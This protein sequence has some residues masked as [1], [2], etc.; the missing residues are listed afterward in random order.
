VFGYAKTTTAL[1]DRMTHHWHF[2]ET[3]NESH[4]F[5]NSTESARKQ[6]RKREEAK[7][8][9]KSEAPPESF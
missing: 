2:V 7:K 5:K 9:S 8:Q 6:I 4:R 1:L 3:G